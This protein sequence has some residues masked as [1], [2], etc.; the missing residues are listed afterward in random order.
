[1]FAHT[2]SDATADEPDDV[3]ALASGHALNPLLLSLAQVLLTGVI[4]GCV[5]LYV[6]ERR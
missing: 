6:D 5:C 4:L 1:M 2:Q 3:F